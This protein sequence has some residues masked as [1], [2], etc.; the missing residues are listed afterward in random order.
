[1]ARRWHTSGVASVLSAF[2]LFCG[3]SVVAHAAPG[4]GVEDFDAAWAFVR[5]AYCFFPDGPEAWDEARRGLR[6][7]AIAAETDAESIRVLEDLLD[8]LADPHSHL[9][10][11][12]ASS[13]RLVPHDV[14]GSRTPDGLLI[15]AVRAGGR[16]EAAGVLPG[17]VVTRI[18]GIRALEVADAIRPAFS[19]MPAAALDQWSALKALAGTHDTP[20]VWTVRSGGTQREIE[21]DRDRPVAGAPPRPVFAREIS[22]SIGFIRIGNLAEPEIVPLVDEVLDRLIEKDSLIIDVRNNRGGDTAIARPI[23]GR[24]VDR[25][26]PYALMRRRHGDGLSQPWTEY[27]HPRGER[28]SG[29]VVI[30]VDRFS[31]SMA[32]GFAMGMRTVAD[33]TVVGTSMAALGAATATFTLPRSGYTLQISAEPVYSTRDEPRWML[34]PDIEVSVEALRRKDDAILEAATR[35]LRAE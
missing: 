27:I 23:M 14:W 32:E 21:I 34:S 11:N 31:A 1:M 28:Y 4:S 30:L 13:H 20:R 29:R 6:D 5:D 7:R 2:S 26:Q 10:V 9:R 3:T 8:Q 35:V 17:D 24:F 19:P 22:D 18:N 25:R 15:E 12:T 33:A 16:A